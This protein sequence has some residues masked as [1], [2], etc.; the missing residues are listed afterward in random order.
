MKKRMMLAVASLATGVVT[1]LITPSAHAGVADGTLNNVHEL[2]GVGLLN[3]SV[4]SDPHS[5]ENNNANTRAEGHQNG[6]EG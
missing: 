6:H 2:T 4:N 5:V 3:T 1:A